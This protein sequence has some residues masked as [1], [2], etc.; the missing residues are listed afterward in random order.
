MKKKIMSLVI[1]SVC[2]M[3][4]IL[5]HPFNKKDIPIV[6]Y[7]YEEIELS[8]E[9]SSLFKNKESE[10]I[11][12]MGLFGEELVYS[13]N[14]K[15]NGFIPPTKG[16]YSYNIHTAHIT[17]LKE[18]DE[19]KYVFDVY[20]DDKTLY[21]STYFM[22]ENQSKFEVIV[23]MDETEI[24]LDS[25]DALDISRVPYFIKDTSLYYLKVETHI[26]DQNEMK[27]SLVNIEEDLSLNTMWESITPQS[28]MPQL[29][30]NEY[31]NST[32]LSSRKQVV[33]STT[34]NNMGTLYYM[35]DYQLEKIDIDQPIEKVIQLK[36]RF[37]INGEIH[38]FVDTKEIMNKPDVLLR[39]TNHYLAFND[40][41]LVY[42]G[43]D[44]LIHFRQ[45]ENNNYKE[46]TLPHLYKGNANFYNLDDHQ[47]LIYY[48]YEEVSKMYIITKIETK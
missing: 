41:T 30:G 32:Y 16:I 2:M 40:D 19:H 46:V 17:K 22:E 38:Y 14:H 43:S 25:G 1:I 24:L 37:I 34:S 39:K 18:F 26:N 9:F 10:S 27:A 31:L 48:P 15:T 33:F 3:G 13:V 6:E 29:D 35:K 47:L 28:Y 5:F 23:S 36:D 11:M 7:S 20:L 4:L 12:Y 45:Y 8:Q 21:F 42:Q 44:S